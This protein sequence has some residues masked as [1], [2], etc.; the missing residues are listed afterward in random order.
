MAIAKICDVCGTPYEPY[1]TI[2]E[3]EE[4]T[5]ATDNPIEI[6]EDTLDDADYDFANTGE[7]PEINGMRFLTIDPY[8]SVQYSHE[9]MDLCEDCRDAITNYIQGLM[10]QNN[11]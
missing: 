5:S 2:I 7:E 11:S 1:G 10:P 3:Q 6:D 9:M 4:D 8:G